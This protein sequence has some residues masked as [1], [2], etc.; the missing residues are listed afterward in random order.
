MRASVGRSWTYEAD[1]PYYPTDAALQAAT[2]QPVHTGGRSGGTSTSLR[3]ELERRFDPHWS[4]GA[5][6]FADRSAYYAPTQWL[7][8]LRRSLSPQRGEVPLPRPVQPYS[9]F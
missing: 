8:Y 5:S 1:A 7:F 9:Q 3:A 2:A 6:V 4:A